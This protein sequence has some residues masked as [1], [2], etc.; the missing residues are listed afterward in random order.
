MGVSVKMLQVKLRQLPLVLTL[1]EGSCDPR[2]VPSGCNYEWS[3][4]YLEEMSIFGSQ[5]SYRLNS[6]KSELTT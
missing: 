1:E 5:E 2:S 3:K 6:A 4:S